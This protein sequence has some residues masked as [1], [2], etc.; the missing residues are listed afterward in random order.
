MI[1]HERHGYPEEANNEIEGNK[2]RRAEGYSHAECELGPAGW[3]PEAGLSFIQ[4]GRIDADRY[5]ST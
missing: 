3:R 5:E 4:A 1:V 2:N